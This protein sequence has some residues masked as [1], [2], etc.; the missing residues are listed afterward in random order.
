MSYPGRFLSAVRR[1]EQFS[2]DTIQFF[3]LF[4]HGKN[5]Q[6]TNGRYRYDKLNKY[7]ITMNWFTRLPCAWKSGKLLVTINY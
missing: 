3:Y 5:L 1:H 2:D 7:K 4:K 6:F